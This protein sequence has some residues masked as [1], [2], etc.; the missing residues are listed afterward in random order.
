MSKAISK[1]RTFDEAQQ[2]LWDRY[3]FS[4]IDAG[5][6]PARL[7]RKIGEEFKNQSCSKRRFERLAEG[8]KG[9]PRVGLAWAIGVCARESAHFSSGPLALLMAGHLA[10]LVAVLRAGL[11]V[12]VENE[13]ARHYAFWLERWLSQLPH[14]LPFTVFD[15]E[16]SLRS[17]YDNVEE[18]AR[19]H[20][21]Y[22]KF[23]AGMR[24]VV[25]G[26][27]ESVE[28][29]RLRALDAV[30]VPDGI[31]QYFDQEPSDHDIEASLDKHWRA[32]IVLALAKNVL[33]YGER[34]SLIRDNIRPA[35]Y[36]WIRH[37]ASGKQT[38]F[39]SRKIGN[40]G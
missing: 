31:V 4:I 5:A 16:P 24:T 15:E 8:N 27:E 14:L 38:D 21:S 7:V 2:A 17:L 29:Y 39:G 30:A 13:C 11:E 36:P 22:A 40:A 26:P 37:P 28:R 23:Q 20:F 35:L 10:E 12:A 19:D 18:H 25:S 1:P 33:T 9:L 32:A 3:F 34:C 6:T